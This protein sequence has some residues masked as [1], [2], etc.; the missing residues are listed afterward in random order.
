VFF[1][2]A[3][4]H[5]RPQRTL[6]QKPKYASLNS[7][8]RMKFPRQAAFGRPLPTVSIGPIAWLK[9]ACPAG[10]SLRCRKSPGA[11]IVK[12]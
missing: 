12:D 6:P 2:A 3:P 8:E 7:G 1:A 11:W 9:P 5:G 10:E 4:A